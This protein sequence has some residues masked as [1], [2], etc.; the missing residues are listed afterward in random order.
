MVSTVQGHDFV[1]GGST[2]GIVRFREIITLT[3]VPEL[4]LGWVHVVGNTIVGETKE[5]C[6][7]DAG[8]A[9]I[10]LALLELELEHKPGS[11]SSCPE[12]RAGT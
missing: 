10:D 3:Y 8:R 11:S 1:N 9:V 12:G 4:F 5:G 7:R 2:T 6:W